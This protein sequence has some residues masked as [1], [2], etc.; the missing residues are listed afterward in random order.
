[1]ATEK[2]LK[3]IDEALRFVWHPRLDFVFKKRAKL[4]GVFIVSYD[5]KNVYIWSDDKLPGLKQIPNTF[6]RYHLCKIPHKLRKIRQGDQKGWS[7]GLPIPE[8]RKILYPY[9]GKQ[10]NITSG[11]LLTQFTEAH[12]QLRKSKIWPTDPYFTYES[13]LATIVHEFGHCYYNSF[14]SWHSN[15]KTYFKSAL[16]LFKGKKDKFTKEKISLP[17]PSPEILSE[18]Y[19]FCAEYYATKEFR[20]RH[21]KNID[22]YLVNNLEKKIE[23]EEQ[24]D[25]FSDWHTIAATLGKLIISRH[26]NNWPSILT[27][28]AS[29]PLQV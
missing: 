10:N 24:V 5:S 4:K 22:I 15:S 17:L 26:P 16:E 1:M 3:A 25:I 11:A 29:N 8:I 28:T 2:D 18:I 20:S 9:L 21:R 7:A 6:K 13:Y 12:K 19:A 27:T 23:D 14:N